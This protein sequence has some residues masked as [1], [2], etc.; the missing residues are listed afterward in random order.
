MRYCSIGS[1][2]HAYA[3]SLVK[4]MH[5]VSSLVC[6]RNESPPMQDSALTPLQEC[7]NLYAKCPNSEVQPNSALKCPGKT[8]SSTNLRA[9]LQSLVLMPGLHHFICP[10]VETCVSRFNSWLA[11]LQGKVSRMRRLSHNTT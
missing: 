8:H 1:D 5:Q 9:A 4:V 7:I 6:S 11:Q 2:R 3:L 10:Q